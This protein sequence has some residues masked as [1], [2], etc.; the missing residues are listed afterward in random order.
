MAIN[1]THLDA[2]ERAILDGAAKA[3][4]KAANCAGDRVA[5]KIQ[6]GG[7]GGRDL[8]LANAWADLAAEAE[9]MKLEHDEGDKNDLH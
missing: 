6:A 3:F 8:A 5:A 4:R 2:V 1:P 7:T 9:L